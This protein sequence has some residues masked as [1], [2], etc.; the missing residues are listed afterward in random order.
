MCSW[1]HGALEASLRSH[2]VK[3]LSR[4]YMVWGVGCADEVR[5]YTRECMCSTLI[6]LARCPHGRQHSRCKECGDGHVTI[7]EAKEV[8]DSDE[9]GEPND[10]P[11]TAQA[12]VGPRGGKRKR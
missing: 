10:W 9:E 6:E 1:W 5:P 4:V 2:H 8:E 3:Y 7:L 12:H 11:T